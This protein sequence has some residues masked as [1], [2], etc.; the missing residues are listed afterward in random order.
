MGRDMFGRGR[1]VGRGGRGSV[2]VVRGKRGRGEEE[3]RVVRVEGGVWV[4]D[5]MRIEDGV[6]IEIL[7]RCREGC[8]RGKRVGVGDGGRVGK[9]WL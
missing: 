2:G 4:I 5:R 8:R 7:G 6:R 3:K 1:D 9:V